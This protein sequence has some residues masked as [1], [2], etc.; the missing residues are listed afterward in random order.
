[1]MSPAS[2]LSLLREL[3]AE[4]GGGFNIAHMLVVAPPEEYSPL[5][6]MR[7]ALKDPS[8]ARQ[9]NEDGELPIHLAARDGRTDLV[10]MLLANYPDGALCPDS[11]GD[12]PLHNAARNLHLDTVRALVEA[13]P[14]ARSEK[15]RRHETAAAVA[16]K[17]RRDKVA[18]DSCLA[19]LCPQESDS[20]ERIRVQ[21]TFFTPQS[22]AAS[23]PRTKAKRSASVGAAAEVIVLSDDDE[24]AP[25]SKKSPRPAQVCSCAALAVL[26]QKLFAAAS[27]L[28]SPL[29][30]EQAVTTPS[31]RTRSQAQRHPRS[32]R[33]P[34]P[35]PP[36]HR[37]WIVTA[38]WRTKQP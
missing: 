3:A 18:R 12:L 24:A 6:V 28:A 14:G 31:G 10:R 20:A 34:P 22:S 19:I 5:A 1:M 38:R 13:S 15:N 8:V 21:P 33:P 30:V 32:E 17:V 27:T 4:E 26:G 7:E 16:R 35:P 37:R 9:K 25:P 11:I 29:P 23:V 36:P 2:A